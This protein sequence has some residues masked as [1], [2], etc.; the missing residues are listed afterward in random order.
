MTDFLGQT[1]Y[2]RRI[3]PFHDAV[4]DGK[5]SCGGVQVNLRFEGLIAALLCAILLA[6][7]VPSGA[8][9][10]PTLVGT[11]SRK[12]HGLAGAFD[13][14]LA[15]VASN[16]TTEPRLGP[17][18]TI[19]FT[20]DG[21]VTA[22]TAAVSE[23]T[24]TVGVPTFSGNELIVPLT[25]VSNAQYVT[26]TV[27][28]VSTAAGGSGGN[29]ST[30]IG[31][32]AGDVNQNRVVSVA[33]LGL[34]NAQLAQFVTGSNYLKDVNATGTLTLADKAITNTHLTESL[35]PPVETAPSVTSTIPAANA[36]GVN[37]G[38]NA[39]IQFSEPVTVSGAWFQMACTSG[40]RTPANTAVTGDLSATTGTTFTLDPN[41]DFTLG[42]VCTVTIF[43][44][45]ISDID[46]NDPPDHMAA[47]FAF[48]FTVQTV[49]GLFEKPLPWNKDVSALSPSSRS[50][51]IIA[52]LISLGGWGNGNK[53]QIDFAITLLNADS[54]TP[55]RTIT[56]SP[57]GYCFGGPDCDPVPLQMPLPVNGNT[58]GS[59]DYN[60]D[61]VHE[62][63]HV[64]VVERT[65]KKLYELYNATAAGS[66]F[67]ALG[68]FVWDLTKQYGDT[69]RGE[70]CTSADAAGLPIAALLATADEVAAGEVPHALRF[71]LPNDHMKADVYV[72]P[73]THAGGPTSPN[74]NAPPYGVRFRLKASFD[75]TP[76]SANAR[77]IL[78]AMKK[79][80]IIL[81]DGGS[82]ALTFGADRLST[83][84]WD[85][86]GIDSHAFF[87]V[88]VS[89]F[90]VVDL[91][92]EIA[93]TDDCVRAP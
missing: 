91:G 44:S 83:A 75:E 2:Y 49:G 31:F 80:G 23:G 72:H 3:A 20:F 34:V 67:T 33:D 86:L 88:A 25:A 14:A 4:L 22:G 61:T 48:T 42:D 82:I 24:A 38:A 70:Q 81:S 68:A 78:H 71:I 17:A 59:A 19:V 66:N 51:A 74:A 87:G 56:A 12:V 84:K 60:C 21:V 18:H 32:L 62:D 29:G 76:Y 55:R 77:V 85:T 11:L 27:S 73:A 64:L 6:Y 54:T 65:E 63:C 47:D 40:T 43:A 10:T 8:Q 28:N 37:V 52:E 90:E 45:G 50:P 15:S 35:P 53:M 89:D 39:T 92:A 1:A 5:V 16:P 58:E 7:S 93:L 79:Y 26:V 9:A 41:V 57:G 30:R 46:L 13:L 36:T 69:L